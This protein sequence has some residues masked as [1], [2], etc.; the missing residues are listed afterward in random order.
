MN[1]DITTVVISAATSVIIVG[2][3]MGA[4]VNSVRRVVKDHDE[5]VLPAVEKVAYLEQRL[6]KLESQD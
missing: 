1:V 3:F 6:E 2:M 4:L 5:K